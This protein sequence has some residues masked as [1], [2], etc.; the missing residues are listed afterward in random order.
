[1]LN[2]CVTCNCLQYVKYGLVDIYIHPHI[3]DSVHY[4]FIVVV[5]LFRTNSKK[6]LYMDPVDGEL[7]WKCR[8]VEIVLYNAHQNMYILPDIFHLKL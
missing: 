4:S 7:P 8:V 3:N 6:N 2:I 1:M 5:G